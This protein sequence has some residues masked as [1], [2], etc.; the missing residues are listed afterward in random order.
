MK[1]YAIGIDIGGTHTKLAL[2]DKAGR[3]SYRA[4]V[5]TQGYSDKDSLLNALVSETGN[6]LCKARLSFDDIAGVGIGVPGIV[7]FKRG[8]IHY[9]TNIPGWKNVALK[10]ILETKLNV[11]VLA[12]NDVNLMAWGEYKF[13]AGRGA[14]NIVCITLGTGVGGGIIVEGKLYRGASSAS[15]EIGHIPIK[16]K[17]LRC[18][19][20]GLGCLERYVGNKYIVSG[21]QSKIKRGDSTLIRQ[22]VNG[23]LSLITPEIISYAA[24]RKDALAVGVW[25]DAGRKIGF[26]LSGVINLLN[27]ERIIIGGGMADAGYVLFKAVRMIIEERALPVNRKIVKIVKAGLGNDAG[28]IGAAALLF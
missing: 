20:G 22:L 10:K 8:F 5:P 3:L 6:I 11:R 25:E 16:E 9:L 19:C 12:D 2:V 4:Q 14:E 21:V 18:N 7:D 28:M 26:V 23:D 13:G 1:R 27:P 24:R 15:G 17:G